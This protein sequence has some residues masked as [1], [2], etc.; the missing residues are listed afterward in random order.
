MRLFSLSL[1]FFLLLG[2]G[3]L[4]QQSEPARDSSHE[5]FY[6]DPKHFKSCGPKALSNI[7]KTFNK[8][9]DVNF[10]SYSVQVNFKFNSFLRNF[11]AI[12]FNDEARGITFQEEMIYILEKNGLKVERIDDFGKL[13][14][15]ID[16]ALV[17]IH[18]R[19]TLNYH[20]MAFPVD[21]NILSFFE[22]ETIVEDV[23]LVSEKCRAN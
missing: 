11:L 9:S 5:K 6:K 15:Q 13:K 8:E 16:V 4:K 12:F 14:D 21:E 10:L 20:W 7:L 22:E 17:L 2:C 19:N 23:Y 18:E 3:L 1:V